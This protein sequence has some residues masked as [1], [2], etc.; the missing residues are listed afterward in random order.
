MDWKSEGTKGLSIVIPAYNEETNLPVYVKKCLSVADKQ[1]LAVEV[2]IVDD[3]STDR[4]GEVAEQLAE[5]F[6]VVQVVRHKVNRGLGQALITG[7]ANVRLDLVTWYPADGQLPASNIPLM[8]SE[9]GDADVVVG[10]SEYRVGGPIRVILSAGWRFFIRALL[11]DVPG[12]EENY[13]F[14][15]HLLDNIQLTC[16]TG[17]VNFEFLIKAKRRGY[18]FKDTLVD[19]APRMS[20]RSKVANISTI[21]Q[22]ARNVIQLRSRLKKEM[23][24]ENRE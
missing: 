15:R 17:M 1:S 8:L 4:T 19:V 24:F 7:Y 22:V 23:H 2:V 18:V 12:I 11:G 16:E 6:A 14:R 5:E 10:R 13:L 9:L 21:V 20:G 3:G